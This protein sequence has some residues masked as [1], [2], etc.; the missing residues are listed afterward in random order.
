MTRDASE[1]LKLFTDA[2]GAIKAKMEVMRALPALV[3]AGTDPAKAAAIAD[4]ILTFFE[5]VVMPHHHEEERELWPVLD[6]MKADNEGHETVKSVIHQLRA[7]HHAMEKLWRE[8]EPWMR[9]VAHRKTMDFD[10][11]KVVTLSEMYDAHAAFE[12]SVVMPMAK[13][14]LDPADQYRIAMGVALRRHP[15]RGYI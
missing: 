14:L 13:F 4:D 9:K 10:T 12:D 3:A 7:E 11:A 8:I 1:S 2:H 5:Q 6:H 15:V